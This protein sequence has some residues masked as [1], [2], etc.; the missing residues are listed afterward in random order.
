MV[1]LLLQFR[2]LQS[3]CAGAAANV[4]AAVVHLARRATCN[5]RQSQL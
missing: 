5:A 3:W 2:G 4:S 1:L